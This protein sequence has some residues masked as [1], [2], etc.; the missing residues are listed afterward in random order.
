MGSRGSTEDSGASIDGGCVAILLPLLLSGSDLGVIWAACVAGQHVGV[1]CAQAR[2]VVSG[3]RIDLALD[4]TNARVKDVLSCACAGAGG[5]DSGRCSSL[6]NGDRCH[7]G[8][9]ENL[10]LH[11]DEKSGF[12]RKT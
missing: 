7:G 8:D 2:V 1:C 6:C 11:V 5:G 12:Q 9:E 4:S 10:E 3:A